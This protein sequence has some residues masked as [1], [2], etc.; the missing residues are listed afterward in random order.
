MKS[1]T[2][3]AILVLAICALIIVGAVAG[4]INLVRNPSD[5]PLVSHIVRTRAP[6]VGVHTRLTDEV[7]EW[8]IR[9]TLEM[10]REMGAPWIVE[11]FPWGYVESQKGRFDWKHA[12]T[13]IKNANAQGL[14]VVAR[15]DFVPEWARPKETTSR[16]LGR[17][18][19][20]DYGEFIYSF[21]NRYKGKV[22]YYVIWNEP[23]L[24][25]EWGYRPVSPEDYTEL[26]K[27]A[28]LN[29][30]RADPDAIVL[31][32]GLAPTL[33]N[34]D[35]AMDDLSFLSRMYQ[36]GARDYFDALAVHAYGGKLP[37]DDPPAPDRINFARV[38]LLR[39]IM[40]ANGDD[41][42]SILVTEAGWND[43]PRWTKA[44]RPGLRMEYTVRAYQKASEEWPWAKA[45]AM[46]VFRL[47]FPARNYN[48]YYTFLTPEF[49][50]KP[51]YE[52]VKQYA[53]GE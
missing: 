52:A 17:D 32:A 5:A 26:L 38:E 41:H 9:K 48:D 13:V 27:V 36:A 2:R 23:N 20:G 42:K 12:D 34:S 18:H 39:E 1:G 22:R 10:V 51:V 50:A 28:Y 7:E 46:W 43:H 37:P 6:I 4:A 19:F 24:S 35:M 21:V 44:V 8:K 33:E 49:T 30:K 11:Y 31:A 47:P 25:F 14:N 3:Q 45:V 15:I 29:A 16:Y 53:G 40:V